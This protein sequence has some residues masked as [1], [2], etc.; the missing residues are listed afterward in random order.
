MDWAIQNRV[1][2]R[3]RV[4]IAESQARLTSTWVGVVI[5]TVK[6][7]EDGHRGPTLVEW[8][9]DNVTSSDSRILL[10]RGAPQVATFATACERPSL[11]T[12]SFTCCISATTSIT[13][14]HG[15]LVVYWRHRRAHCGLSTASGSVFNLVRSK[16][17]PEVG[18]TVNALQ[19]DIR[20]W[21]DRQ[22][23]PRGDEIRSCSIAD[24][25]DAFLRCGSHF[26]IWLLPDSI[27][28]VFRRR[29]RRRVSTVL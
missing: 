6:G 5:P 10:L 14:L 27:R 25:F 29:V 26:F 11:G 15:A 13:L 7:L 3:S 16:R 9:Y 4:T 23:I 18:G 22:S 20:T 12:S 8:F 17:P 2:T 24:Y 21:S 1:A 28:R 19:R